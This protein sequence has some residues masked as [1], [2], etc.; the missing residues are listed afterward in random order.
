M[1]FC[2]SGAMAAGSTRMA[3]E[4]TRTSGYFLDI[5]RLDWTDAIPDD[6]P[7]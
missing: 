3:R 5:G 4:P 1:M 2:I 6:F 7:S